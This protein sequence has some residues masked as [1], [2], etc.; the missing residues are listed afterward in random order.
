MI[1]LALL[2]QILIV[3][4]TPGPANIFAL[5]TGIRHGRRKGFRVWLGLLTGAVI[6]VLL[7]ALLT[8]LI[9]EALGSYVKYLKYLGALYL[10]YL[11]CRIY[12]T[13]DTKS[14]QKGESTFLSGML[15][16]LTNAKILLFEISV[17]STFVLPY[18]NSYADMLP[19]AALLLV[20]GPGANFLWM[21]AGSFLSHLYDAHYK[22]INI[23]SAIALL[24][25]AVYIAFIA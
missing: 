24:L 3:G 21:M 22:S 18:S 5:T 7:M 9:G 20:A 12:E 23:G 2:L 11:S 8:H 16:Q 10:V 1:T 17:F 14:S 25:C 13:H 4:Y 19:V 15:M 6:A